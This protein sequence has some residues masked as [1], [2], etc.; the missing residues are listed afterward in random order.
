MTSTNPSSESTGQPPSNYCRSGG[1]L[2]SL[3]VEFSGRSLAQRGAREASSVALN[4]LLSTVFGELIRGVAFPAPAVA[5]VGF[6]A[7]AV[8]GGHTPNVFVWD[9]QRRVFEARDYRRNIILLI[10]SVCA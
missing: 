1:S 5:F 2:T 9:P 6:R 4:G 8:Q 3:S 10:Q 7:H